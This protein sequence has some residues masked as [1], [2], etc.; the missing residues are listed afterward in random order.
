MFRLSKKLLSP[1]LKVLIIPSLVIVCVVFLFLTLIKMGYP[2]ITTLLSQLEESGKIERTLE[3]R[4]NVL[5][6][7]NTGLSKS[8]DI[9]FIVLPDKNPGTWT[10]SQ[11]KELSLSNSLLFTDTEFKKVITASDSAVRKMDITADFESGSISPVVE[12]LLG[13]GEV[14]P[15]TTIEEVEIERDKEVINSKVKFTIYWAALP[16]TLPSLTQPL[17]Q[18]SITDQE[19]LTK[20]DSYKKP[21]FTVLPPQPAE[22]LRVNPFN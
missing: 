14:A 19:T 17:K 18:L 8:S 1:D 7:F 3:E 11:I 22:S 13:M 2:R 10:L 12:F 15:L 6:E 9:S 5:K 16:T 21:Q 4:L 20:I